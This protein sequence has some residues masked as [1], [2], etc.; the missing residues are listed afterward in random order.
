MVAAGLNSAGAWPPW[1]VI[2]FVLVFWGVGVGLLYGAV[3]MGRRQVIIDVVDGGLLITRGTLRGIQQHEWAAGDIREVR[4]GPSGMEINGRP[5]HEL[6]IVPVSG[7]PVG[8][9]SQRS[10]E[11]LA[12]ISSV[13]RSAM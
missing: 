7:K 13:V 8:L 9:L 10:D 12:W 2:L 1:P 6:Q 4:V 5:V 3:N 11:E